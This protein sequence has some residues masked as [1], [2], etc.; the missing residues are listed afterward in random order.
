MIQSQDTRRLEMALRCLEALCVNIESS[1]EDIMK[2]GGIPVLVG[3]LCSDRLVVQCMATAVLCHMSE[4]AKVCEDLVHHGAVPVLIKLLSGHQPELHSRCAVILADLAGHSE[5]H[6]NLIAQ[7]GGVALVVKLLTSDLQDVLVNA[8]RCIRTL[9]VKS[10][11]NQT[12]VAHAGGVPHLV[13]FLSVNSE[14]LQE[15]ACLA[16]AEL[17]RG[18]QENQELICEAGAVGALVQALRERKIPVKVKAATALESIASQ[19]P[20]IQQCFLRQS[21]AKDLL[22]LLKVFQL[23]VREQG[24][25]ALWALAGQ[26][27]KQQKLMA[28]QMGYPVILDLLLSSSDKMQYVGCQAAIALSRDSRTHQDGFC[29]EYGV[30]PLVRLLRGSRTTLK[31]LLR[32]IKALGCLCIGVALTTNKKSQKIIYREKAIP[33]LLELLK[34]HES[35]EVQVQVAKTLACVLL[36][37]QK[38][39]REFWEQEDFSYDIILELMGAENKSICLDAGHALSLFA[40]NNKAQQKAI[41][42]T[43][44]ILMNTYEAFLSSDNETER[45]KAAF[46]I[47]VLARVISGSDEVTLTAR[48]VTVLVELL[49]SDQSTT[50]VITAQLLASLVH[51]RA[52]ITNAIVTMGAVEHLSAHLDSEDE[53]VR[54]ACAS[55]LGY[56]TSNRYA[57]RQLLAKCR[58]SPHIYDLL[59]ENLAKDA[60]I[61][62]FFTAEFER[63]RRIG[64]PSLSLEINGGPPVPHRDNK[65]LAKRVNDRCSQSAIGDR[66]TPAPLPHHVRQRA[67][68]ANP[69]FRTGQTSCHSAPKQRLNENT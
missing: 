21:A 53:E 22:Q 31:T 45:A 7:L 33:T 43:G 67:R 66:E 58:K 27:L 39:Q 30:P 60:R 6:Q 52:G 57:H 4:N 38:L 35:L 29:R 12:A 10:P 55:A 47:V 46:Q 56:L 61:S 32:V 40:Y 50:V 19:N 68:T 28:Q 44:R 42:Q 49:Q 64:L 15:E 13:E 20:A 34:T 5:Q 36:G 48:G 3:L 62:Q 41:R 24:A 25:T 26:T 69:R 8:V 59:M 1:C 18:H 23:D 17:A 9:C 37:N 2:A 14:V 51:T 16:L 65:G 54:T 63:Q 11:C